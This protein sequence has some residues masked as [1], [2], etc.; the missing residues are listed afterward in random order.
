MQNIEINFGV[1]PCIV[2][3]N[4]EEKKAL[5]HMWNNFAK[6][7]AADV[8]AGGCPEGQISIVFGIVEYE[9]GSVDEVRPAQIR[10]V[11]NKIKG[12]AFEED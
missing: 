7:V 5:F 11:D 2:K 3:Q 8:Y 10:F 12:Y 6:P 4:G 1:R 9:D